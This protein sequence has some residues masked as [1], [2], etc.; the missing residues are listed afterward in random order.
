MY[1]RNFLAAG[2]YVTL[3]PFGVLTTLQYDD[4]GRI[5][6]VFN[7]PSSE[8]E[9]VTDKLLP[10][11]LSENLVP[12][13]IGIKNGTSWITGVFYSPEASY[14]DI[15]ELPDCIQAEAI[16]D[17]LQYPGKFTFKASY[18]HSL[19][20]VYRGAVGVRQWLTSAKF[21]TLPGYSISFEMDDD[22]F[23]EMVEHAVQDNLNFPCLSGYIVF[24]QGEPHYQSLEWKL[25]K[26]DDI[27]MFYDPFGTLYSEIELS[28]GDKLSVNY[29]EVVANRICKGCSIITANS[30]I[31]HAY[32]VDRELPVIPSTVACPVCGNQYKVNLDGRTMCSDRHCN[33]RLYGETNRFLR[34]LK[35]PEV[36]HLQYT[37]Y[38]QDVGASYRVQDI[39]DM[40]EYSEMPITASLYNLLRSIVPTDVVPIDSPLL[41]K[42]TAECHNSET[43]VEY[44]LTHTDK[45]L[46][47]LGDAA[48]KLCIWLADDN[49]CKDI[50]N[51][52]HNKHIKIDDVD[53]KFDGDPIMRSLRILLTGT[54]A[55]GSISEVSQILRSYAAKIVYTPEEAN[56]LIIG[57]ISEDIRSNW[58]RKMEALGG[59]VVTESKF[60]ES[61]DIDSDLRENL[62]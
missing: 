59:S 49:N 46:S 5:Q 30:E 22:K 41:A 10:T 14:S 28:S 15:G 62:V 31:V 44:Y 17:F 2:D 45:L 8:S 27:K 6:K 35:L 23:V 12:R 34:Q 53:K 36:T 4:E 38:T 11:I 60:F 29:G 13:S 47:T 48:H 7:G 26:V 19:A 33:S 40:E 24:R 20:A 42:F 18:V 55:H 3:L 58:I 16:S 50:V 21:D 61:Y 37:K 1:V 43:T 57:D 39:L 51:L 9:D 52:L 56:I 25:D 54:F 32:S